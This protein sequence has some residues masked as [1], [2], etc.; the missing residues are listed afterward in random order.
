M[1][2]T[3]ALMA[4]WKAPFLNGRS[5]GLEEYERVPSGNMKTDCRSAVMC[6]AAELNASMAD[7]WLARLMKTVLDNDT[8]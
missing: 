3:W 6:S 7:L 4:R 1:I 2:G 8:V 5:S